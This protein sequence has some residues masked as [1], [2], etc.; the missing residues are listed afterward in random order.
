MESER[1]M[2]LTKLAKNLLAVSAL[3]VASFGANAGA[4]AT[5]DLTIDNL[6]FEFETLGAA[7]GSPASGFS[8]SEATASVNNIGDQDAWSSG[9]L[10]LNLTYSVGSGIDTSGTGAYGIVNLSGDLMNG[11]S[12]GITDSSA[13]AYGQDSALGTANVQNIVSA[14]FTGFMNTD[15]LLTVSFDWLVE[16]YSEITTPIAGQTATSSYGFELE[17]EGSDDFWSVDL[18]DLVD[19]GSNKRTQQAMGT[20]T[21]SDA[22]SYTSANNDVNDQFLLDNNER[23]TFTITQFTRSDVVSV[24]EPTSVAILGL[25][26]LGLAGVS[27]R[28]KS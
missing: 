20:N 4:I 1:K 18:R 15:V 3:T 6:L 21:L 25:S 22:G 5:A 7:P 23:Y 9:G 17:I 11:G 26:L 28:R 16:L 19:E 12:T 8:G 14:S 27:R 13:S 2:K 10:P 24:A